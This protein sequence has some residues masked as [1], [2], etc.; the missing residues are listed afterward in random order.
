[1]ISVTYWEVYDERGN[2]VVREDNN[3]HDFAVTVDRNDN[4]HSKWTTEMEK[5]Y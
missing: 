5:S 4:H 1:M 2:V 3:A